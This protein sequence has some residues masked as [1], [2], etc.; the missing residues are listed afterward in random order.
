MKKILGKKSL[1][2]IELEI[3]KVNEELKRHNINAK[4]LYKH[5]EESQFCKF[6]CINN[7]NT[8]FNLILSNILNIKV[9]DVSWIYDDSISI[10]F[11]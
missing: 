9:K 2:Y 5:E 4:C 3:Y 11:E 10:I 7:T 6:S 1:S 8:N